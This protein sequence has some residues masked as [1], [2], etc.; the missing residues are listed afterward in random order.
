MARP[1]RRS[2]SLPAEATSFIGR[3][4]E[5]AEI[6]RKLTEARL[7]SLVGP[8][9]VGK[10][11]LAVRAGGEL[12]R[13]FPDGAWLV[14]LADIRD[15]TLV[16]SA[17]MTALGLR[18]AAATEP[19]TLILSYL[20]DRDLMLIVDNCEH[21]LEAAAR[22]VTEVLK[23][24]PGVRILAT[25]REPLSAPGEHI[26]PV[27]PLELP[28]PGSAEPLARV[29]ENEAVA[30][31][32]ERAAA[33]CG[34]FELTAANRTH[35]V[36]LC[37]RLD[38][39]PLAIELAA[40]RTRVLAVGQILDRLSDRFSLLTGGGRAALPRHQT[41]QTTI[42]WSHD[43]LAEDERAV[44]RRSCVFAGGFTMEDAES[45]CVPEGT[46][47]SR[48]LDLMASLVDKSLVRREDA[49]GIACYRLHE[50]MR[51]YAR[52]KLKQADEEDTIELRCTEYYQV[53]CHQPGHQ[54]RLR[55]LEWL[56]WADLEI[57]NIRAV[58]H[59]C[60]THCDT[61]RGVALATSLSWYWITR[62]TTE[63]MRW[64]GE[65]LAAE[66]GDP[67]LRAWAHFIRGFLAVLKA[68]PAAAEPEL[69]TAAAAARDHGQ[70]DL[71]TEALCMGSVAQLIAGDR[72]AAERLLAEA[73]TVIAE[74]DYPHGTLAVLQTQVF[75]GFFAADLAAVR[76][77]ATEA[78]QLAEQ[79]GDL[80]VLE[81]MLLNL[82]SAA[83]LDGAPDEAE[84]LLAKA[85]TLA[86]TIDDRVAQFYLLA[87]HGC[88][89]AMSSQAPRA[90]TL[91]GAAD[92]VRAEAGANVMP[93]LT[94]L[95]AQSQKSARTALGA[96]Q[97]EAEFA[98]GR[99]L[100]REQAIR[101][102]LGETQD[103]EHPPSGP[104]TN[105]ATD[106]AQTPLAKRE[107]E[108]ARL[109]AEGLTNK[110]IATRLFISERTVDSHIRSILT[111]L[112]F[113]T[114]TQIATWIAAR[115]PN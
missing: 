66:G 82:G 104:D 20:Q 25:S 37:R 36:E 15:P 35:V 23:A 84:P 24:A 92:A 83:L 5:L 40:V 29:R 41:L 1:I 93:M 4:G 74:I 90:A 9:G 69:R 63:G 68:D 21:L 26:V 55:L 39:L 100:D 58:L 108:V 113:R 56:P 17:V 96:P 81:V 14:E 62:A 50:T 48:A 79:I 98:H 94:T 87:T 78:T 91:L 52:L 89:A 44:L 31:F 19:L 60:L 72:P 95:L 77:A 85:L 110:Q 3:R 102:A 42:E 43:L 10:T 99:N 32:V 28:A 101:L 88:H 61:A 107:V 53:R 46:P 65:F 16:A 109:V 45:V 105:S 12:G 11:R 86:R 106:P 64:L 13:G 22:M 38:G 8:G 57:D 34:A 49:N 115:P 111:K 7:V 33:A 51:E 73:K 112:G 67:E 114:R 75:H 71:L 30:L 80:Y 27:A 54:V 18:D 2:G 70:R 103:S 59:R 76:A 47:A 97:F 6:R